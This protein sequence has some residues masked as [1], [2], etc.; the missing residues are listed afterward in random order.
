MVTFRAT[1]HFQVAECH[2]EH[3]G[4]VLYCDTPV[5]LGYNM[6]EKSPNTDLLLKFFSVDY[7]LFIPCVRGQLSGVGSLST[8]WILEIKLRALG[9]V[10]YTHGDM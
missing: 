1:A 2:V 7:I 9:L 4:V 3:T 6:V 5:W 8:K 10:T